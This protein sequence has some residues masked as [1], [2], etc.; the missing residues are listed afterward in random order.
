MQCTYFAV[1]RTST[2][3]TIAV[4]RTSTLNTIAVVRTSTLNTIAVDLLSR[5]GV[6][7]LAAVYFMVMVGVKVLQSICTFALLHSRTNTSLPGACGQSCRGRGVRSL[8]GFVTSLPG[9]V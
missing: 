1:L 5:S 6:W 7:R 3:N 9:V 2:L 8:A 4:L